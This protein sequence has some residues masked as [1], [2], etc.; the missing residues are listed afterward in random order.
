M[1]LCRI[2]CISNF[3]KK[4]KKMGQ[5]AVLI[6]IMTTSTTITKETPIKGGKIIKTNSL[7]TW[8]DVEEVVEMETE[9][10]GIISSFIKVVMAKITTI[11]IM[12]I[13]NSTTISNN[14]NI[15]TT[16]METMVWIMVGSCIWTT[17][18]WWAIKSQI[19]KIKCMISSSSSLNHMVICNMDNNNRCKTKWCSSNNTI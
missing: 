12:A 6:R 10:M 8:K 19:C 16:C 5:R 3:S 9:I 2:K 11:R 1:T 15:K 13:S 18:K 14:I 4:I 7:S 17:N